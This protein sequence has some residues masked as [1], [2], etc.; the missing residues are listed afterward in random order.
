[1]RLIGS[2]VDE[3]I[4]MAYKNDIPCE[5]NCAIADPQ[6]WQFFVEMFKSKHGYEPHEYDYSE[7]FVHQMLDEQDSNRR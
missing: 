1:M 4:E 2:T 5:K 6:L 7:A 3:I